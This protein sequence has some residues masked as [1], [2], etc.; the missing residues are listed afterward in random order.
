MGG[1][2]ECPS[3]READ[4]IRLTGP[5]A[6]SKALTPANPAGVPFLCHSPMPAH[7]LAQTKNSIRRALW[8]L[9]DPPPSKTEV[10]LLWAFQKAFRLSA[11]TAIWLSRTGIEPPP[12]LQLALGHHQDE[13]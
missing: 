2:E 10:Q 4:R 7:S 5:A 13:K 12:N 11:T 8:N 1:T 9:A 3:R 6:T